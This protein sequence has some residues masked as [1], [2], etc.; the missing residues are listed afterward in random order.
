MHLSLILSNIPGQQWTDEIPPNIA[1]RVAELGEAAVTKSNRLRL[2]RLYLEHVAI[3]PK[4]VDP[5]PV[6]R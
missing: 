5:D 4:A 2:S 1:G 6:F 3:R